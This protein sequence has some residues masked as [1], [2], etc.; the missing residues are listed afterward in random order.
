MSD[1][2]K[3]KSYKQRLQEQELFKTDSK[4]KQRVVN[5]KKQYNRSREKRDLATELYKE[6]TEP[7]NYTKN[8]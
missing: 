2:S 6:F 1:S 5:P 4:Y 8:D 3:E 7:E